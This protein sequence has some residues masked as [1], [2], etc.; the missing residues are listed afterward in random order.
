MSA[1]DPVT[2]I[3]VFQEIHVNTGKVLKPSGLIIRE[4]ITAFLSLLLDSITKI[5]ANL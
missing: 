1:I 5:I 4:P 3:A 2:V